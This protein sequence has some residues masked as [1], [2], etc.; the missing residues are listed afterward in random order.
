MELTLQ[1]NKL[2]QAEQ[3]V[4]VNNNILTLIGE[5]GCGKSAILESVFEQYL[6]NNDVN[7]ICFSS[8]QK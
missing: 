3:V 2:H 5:N 7:L 4:S 6:E 8:G 1:P